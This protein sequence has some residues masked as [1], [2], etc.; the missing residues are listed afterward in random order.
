M[1]LLLSALLLPLFLVG[2]YESPVPIV[3]LSDNSV[4]KVNEEY[5]GNWV[6]DKIPK[7]KILK[8]SNKE[9]LI[10]WADKN[11]NTNVGQ[12]YSVKIKEHDFMIIRNINSE[13]P[14]YIFAKYSLSDTDKTKLLI[15]NVVDDKLFND[16]K[17]NNSETLYKFIEKNINNRELYG[18]TYIFMK[19]NETNY[20]VKL[21]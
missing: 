11:N 13:K 2:C 20:K 5:V 21:N 9:Y 12:G 17:I 15:M 14:S 4:Q 7:L 3:K 8:F 16:K 1:K 10:I 6:G 19:L 18:N